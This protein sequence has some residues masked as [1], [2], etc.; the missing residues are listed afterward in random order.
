MEMQDY[1]KWY[2]QKVFVNKDVSIDSEFKSRASYSFIMTGKKGNVI[3][4]WL[5]YNGRKV[6]R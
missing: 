2:Q 3:K 1:S 6:D 4:K 5:A